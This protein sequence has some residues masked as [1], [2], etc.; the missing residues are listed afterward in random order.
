ME[1][2]SHPS[3]SQTKLILIAD[4]AIH[5]TKRRKETATGAERSKNLQ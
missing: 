5:Q 1:K 4:M 2:V 3:D